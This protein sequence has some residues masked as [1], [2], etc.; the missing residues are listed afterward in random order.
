VTFSLDNNS[1]YTRFVP[2]HLFLNE[3]RYFRLSQTR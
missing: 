1:I 2:I 3:I